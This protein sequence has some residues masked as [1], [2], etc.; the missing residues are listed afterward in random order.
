M[1]TSLMPT[2]LRSAAAQRPKSTSPLPPAPLPAFGSPFTPFTSAGLSETPFDSPAAAAHPR[3]S[4]ISRVAL[5]STEGQLLAL[6]DERQELICS[7][8]GLT[9]KLGLVAL[10]GV[11]LVRLS[12]AYQQR[13]ERQGEISA[14]LD[15]ETARLAKARER[16]DQLFSVEGEQKLIREQSQWIAPNRLRVVWQPTEPS[17]PSVETSPGKPR[18]GTPRP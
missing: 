15:L 3:P 4:A 2:G 5:F 8:I 6:S 1:L 13:M 14:V 12:G 11:S 17:L 16:F 10:A 7:L 18:E 9:V